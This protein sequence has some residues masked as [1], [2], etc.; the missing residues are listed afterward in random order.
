[1]ISG[2][3]KKAARKPRVLFENVTSQSIPTGPVR[4]ICIK[5]LPVEVRSD[6][7]VTLM[8]PLDDSPNQEQRMNAAKELFQDFGLTGPE[9]ETMLGE[10]ID[11]VA[12]YQ[13]W[14]LTR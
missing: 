5:G 7:T 10:L 4:A 8:M 2:S 13:L 9:S 1:M 6:G 3:T 11:R 14:A 12:M